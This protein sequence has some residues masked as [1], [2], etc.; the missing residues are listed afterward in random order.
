MSATPDLL[1]LSWGYDYRPTRDSLWDW[2]VPI[3]TRLFGTRKVITVTVFVVVGALSRIVLVYS[4]KE[5]DV[6]FEFG[7]RPCA[8]RVYKNSK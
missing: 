6:F 3:W 1:F 2:T 8:G 5:T 4:S 7:F